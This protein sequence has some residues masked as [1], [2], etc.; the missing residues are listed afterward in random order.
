M[1]AVFS[2]FMNPI[3]ARIRFKNM[4]GTFRGA[5]EKAFLQYEEFSE[6]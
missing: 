3:F 4:R 6:S 1:V 5:H 2:H